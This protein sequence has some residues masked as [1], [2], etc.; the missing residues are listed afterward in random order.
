MSSRKDCQTISI[1]NDDI[2]ILH[3]ENGTR[4]PNYVQLNFDSIRNTENSLDN[5]QEWKLTRNENSFERVIKFLQ[6]QDILDIYNRLIENS[7]IIQMLQYILSSSVLTL[8]TLNQPKEEIELNNQIVERLKRFK[9]LVEFIS[10]YHKH[11]NDFSG[12]WKNILNIITMV[13]SFKE[14]TSKT[15]LCVQNSPLAV[16]KKFL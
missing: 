12:Q 1:N 14:T 11:K 5:H 8:N 9:S 2:C 15:Q 6:I 7:E 13:I 16:D 3:N 4:N 10:K